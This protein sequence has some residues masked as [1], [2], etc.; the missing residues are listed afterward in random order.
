[1]PNI[2]SKRNFFE[3]IPQKKSALFYDY[4]MHLISNVIIVNKGEYQH[5]PRVSLTKILTKIIICHDISKPLIR[6]TACMMQ[7]IEICIYHND[8]RFMITFIFVNAKKLIKIF[9]N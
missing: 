6:C 2:V 9:L 5:C 1:M 8:G 3:I 4:F 7:C